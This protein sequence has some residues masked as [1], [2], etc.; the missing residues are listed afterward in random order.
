M[1]QTLRALVV[2]DSE[3]DA[4]FFMRTMQRSGST[5]QIHRAANGVA[6]MSFL[7]EAVSGGSHQLP[8]IIFLDLKMPIV[9]GFEVLAWMRDQPALSQVPVVVLSGSERQE[10]K[11]RA[12]EYGVMDYLVKPLRVADLNRLLA[13]I[14]PATGS[15]LP[16]KVGAPS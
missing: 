10:D 16:E 6:A 9:N 3:D 2:E 4:Y 15:S 13:E 7:R 8:H 1:K 11:E 5:C 14:C 12:A